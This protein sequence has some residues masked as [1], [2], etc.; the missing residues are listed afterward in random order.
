MN[1]VST[2]CAGISAA[3]NGWAEIYIRGTTTRATVYY[4]FEAPTSDSSGANIALD[5]YGA[6]EVYVNQ[7]VDIVAKSPDGTVV[8]SWTDGYS[9]PNVEVISPAFTGHDYVSGAAAVNKPTTLQAVLDLYATSSGSK[10]WKVLIGGVEKNLQNAFGSLNGL[11]FNVKDPTYGAVGD[12]V[13]NDQTAI[14]S[15]LAAAVA[16]GGGVVFFPKG[17]YLVT[18]A[19]EWDHK[20]SIVGVGA[21]LSIISTNSPSNARIITWTSGTAQND[22]LLVSGVGF[23]ASQ[24]NSGEQVYAN[25]AVNVA[26]SDCGFGASSN[27]TGNLLRLTNGGN[28]TAKDCRFT[29][30]GSGFCAYLVASN[31]AALGCTFETGNTSYDQALLRLDSGRYAFLGCKLDVA[32]VS[33]LPAALYA[34]E[35]VSSTMNLF[36]GGCY[37]RTNAQSYTACLSMLSGATVTTCGNDYGTSPRYVTSG[38]LASGSHLEFAGNTKATG[39]GAAYTIANSTDLWSL[40]SSGTAPTLTI[41]AIYFPGQKQ[42]LLISN[43]S[44]GGWADLTF[45]SANKMIGVTP[46]ASGSRAY[47]QMVA[48]DLLVTGTYEWYIADARVG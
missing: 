35:V 27:C 18:T 30:Y 21:R 47:V 8:R 33:S 32:L 46:V 6:V 7:L 5:A 38:T 14:A 10:D 37:F 45:P 41:P 11:V 29:S 26:F 12:G 48:S 31:F 13:T 23:S 17:T 9:S 44:G 28:V 40:A 42:N 20:V 36:V 1:L 25:V 15:A 3:A 19:I 2:L 39:A 22:P 24:A 16:A 4:A 34:L 43:T